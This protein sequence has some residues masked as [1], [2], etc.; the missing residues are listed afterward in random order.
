MSKRG[1]ITVFIIVGIVLLGML[2]IFSYTSSLLGLK[3]S[4]IEQQKMQGELG[5]SAPIEAYITSC[6]SSTAKDGILENSRQSGYFILPDNADNKST[7]DLYENVAYYYNNGEILIPS[8]ETFAGEIASYVD[9]MLYLCLD[10]F[11]NF[12]NQGYDISFDEPSSKGILNHDKL[13]I[14]TT[15][16]IKIKKDNKEIKLSEFVVS[17]PA[18]EYYQDIMIAKKIV[19]TMNE[20]DIKGVC[21]TCFSSFAAENNVFVEILEIGNNTTLFEVSDNDYFIN[22]EKYMLRFAARYKENEEKEE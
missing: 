12:K 10:D 19:E 17:I 8:L 18:E 11:N 20:E 3:Q 6:I 9:T 16:P 21:I 2:I 4:G 1:Q 5:L 13:T 15:H 7:T 22:N 14:I